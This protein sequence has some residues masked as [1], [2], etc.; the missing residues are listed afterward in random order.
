MYLS[1]ETGTNIELE[2]SL[3]RLQTSSAFSSAY[4]YAFHDFKFPRFQFQLFLIARSHSRNPRRRPFLPSFFPFTSAERM[5]R[6]LVSNRPFS[7]SLSVSLSV[8]Y[9]LSLCLLILDSVFASLSGRHCNFWAL[10]CQQR[11]RERRFGD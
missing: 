4:S 11:E 10:F 1:T 6:F 8:C 7:P 2:R 3:R 5:Y 9:S